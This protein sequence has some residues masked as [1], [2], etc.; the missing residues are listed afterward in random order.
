MLPC[1]YGSIM[2]PFLS[3]PGRHRAFHPLADIKSGV[4]AGRYVVSDG[5][6]NAVTHNRFERSDLEGC[7]HALDDGDFDQ[8]TPAPFCPT[9]TQDIYRPLYLGGR[10][11]LRVHID[12]AHGVVITAFKRDGFL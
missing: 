1:A 5:A 7:V 2:L 8:S 12:R 11:F 9:I 6:F 4:A 10:M 3:M